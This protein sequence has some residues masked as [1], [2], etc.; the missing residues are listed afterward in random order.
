MIEELNNRKDIFFLNCVKS[1]Y[2]DD[3]RFFIAFL[4]QFDLLKITK[5]WKYLKDSYVR[6]HKRLTAYV[7][8]GSAASSSAEVPKNQVFVFMTKWS[9]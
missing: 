9:F 4:A 7:A 6:N 5:R 2:K 3:P 8:S 1:I